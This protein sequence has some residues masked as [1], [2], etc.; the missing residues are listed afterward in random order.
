MSV[1]AIQIPQSLAQVLNRAGDKSG[2]DFDYLVQT[3][4]RE[5]SFNPEAKARTSSAVGLFQFVEGTWLEVMKLEGD[6]LGYSNYVQ[7]IE[8]DSRWG[9]CDS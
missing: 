3:A 9:I 8:R 6:R 2:V 4:F 5:S 7:A 1:D